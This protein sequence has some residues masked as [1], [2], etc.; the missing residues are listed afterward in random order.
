MRY[1]IYFAPQSGSAL[2]EFG[3]WWLDAGPPAGVAAER[4]SEMTA[5]PRRYGFHATLKPPF[6]LAAAGEQT[7]RTRLAAFA[8]TRSAFEAPPLSIGELG[9]F[10]ALVPRTNDDRLPALAA[11]CVEQFDDMRAQPPPAELARRRS[12]GLT[13]RQDELLRRWGYPYVFDEFRFHM[14][15]TGRLDAD[16]RS[17]VLATLKARYGALAEQPLA[18]DAVALFV[19]PASGA[20]FRELGRY[21]FRR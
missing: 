4:W 1:A 11:A 12:G 15:L 8:A 7:L 2:A 20:P 6:A 19:E 16:E 5:S 9:D 17:R 18:V 13:P 3:R 14:T 21:A 10:L